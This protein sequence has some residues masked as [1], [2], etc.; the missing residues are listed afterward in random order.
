MRQTLAAKQD[1][2]V[3]ARRV[4][5]DDSRTGFV[6]VSRLRDLKP[7]E[8]TVVRVSGHT[9]VLFLH[10]GKVFAVDNR[11]P[12]MGFPLSKG[13]VKDGILTCHWHNARFDL[14]CGGTFDLFADDV[15]SYPVEIR[16]E[17]DDAEVWLDPDPPTRDPVAYYR[18]RLHD[19]LK[20]NL[21]L[22][23]AKAVLGLLGAGAPPEEALKVGAEFGT[24]YSAN[25]WGPGLTILTAMANI[26]P[27]LQPEDQA[28][29]LYQ[30]LTHV[31]R[32]CA[33]TP[34]RFA[35]DPLPRKETQAGILK[36]WFREFIDR[37]DA[38][39]AERCLRTAIE[40]GI[41]SAQVADMIFAACTDHMYRDV[42]HP[43]DFANKA[44]ELLDKIGWE[45]AGI[46]LTSLLRRL[47]NSAR[48]EESSAWRH[49]V[50]LADLLWQEFPKLEAAVQEGQ[51]KQGTWK[52]RQALADT[53]LQEDPAASVR[54][55]TAALRAGAS[56]QEL[57]GVV[58]YAAARR[59]AQFHTRNE[60]GDW[61]TTLH[62]F[63]YSN[64]IHQAM[65]RAPS[66]ELLRGVYDAAMSI[67][68]DRFLNMPAAA[69]PRTNGA[70]A[71]LP[72]GLLEL[73]DKQQQVNEAGALVSAALTAKQSD[74]ELLAALGEGLLREDADFHTFQAIEAAFRQY[75]ELRGTEWGR[76][77]LIAAA[78][79]L[80]AHAPTPRAMGQTYLIAQR[81]HRGEALYE[82]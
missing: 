42:G 71:V 41:P 2:A 57:A 7:D 16:G 31:A 27:W 81:L 72:D 18:S 35:L 30:G 25:G 44:C 46:V 70:G 79:Y 6:R 33:G 77:V 40:S 74:A 20:Y 11:C 8:G 36:Q 3:V 63:T 24:R 65:K 67:Y 73:L 69:L 15:R 53:L 60:F 59:I 75:E 9:I 5:E 1:S 49:P 64:A 78:R 45:N 21:R 10:Q 51:A 43:M 61:D 29:A 28:R 56:P 14:A 58:A 32:E 55:L 66:V 37:R 38:E 76:H 82:G 4:S 39:G 22:V 23:I 52:G 12:H 54:A 13:S 26:L 19:G 47:V 68:L 50:D 34:P 17:G 62:T 48:M 80:A